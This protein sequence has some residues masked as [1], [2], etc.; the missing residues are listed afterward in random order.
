[1]TARTLPLEALFAA[2]ALASAC[3][4]G[5]APPR[6]AT[7]TAAPTPVA[8]TATADAFDAPDTVPAGFL[9]VSLT[10]LGTEPHSATLLRLDSGKTLPE[11]I[12]AYREANRMRAARPAWASYH[13]GSMA[14]GPEAAVTSVLSV[15]PGNYAWVCFMPDSTGSP[16]VL[17]YGH[18]HPFVVQ[19]AGASAPA[20]P[21]VP[22][23]T[24]RM[25]DYAFDVDGP[26]K[27]GAHV[28]RI[29]NAGADPHHALF[30]RLAP[31]KTMDDF[32]AWLQRGMEGDAPSTLVGTM[33]ELSSGAEA[34]LDLDLP[35]GEYVVVCLVA[36]RD[37]VSHLDKGMVRQIR[38]E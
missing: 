16:H 27:A 1:M 10:N 33:G 35:P 31:G 6:T 17:A 24:L 36:G 3:T 21:P 25:A 34:Y 26:L 12:D 28:I 22:T 11:W 38:V 4:A 15:E 9:E 13:G 14:L 37:E 19:P 8:L 2:V 7:S 29:V 23:A 20:N 18:A 32:T 5:E 30:F